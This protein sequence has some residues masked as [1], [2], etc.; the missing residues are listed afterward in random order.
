MHFYVT[1]SSCSVT[2]LTVVSGWAQN[3]GTP[4]E[5]SQEMHSRSCYLEWD[6][7]W[8]SLAGSRL[9]LALVLNFCGLSPAEVED[10][11]SPMSLGFLCFE[12]SQKALNCPKSYV[13]VFPVSHSSL[14]TSTCLGKSFFLQTLRQSQCLDN[15]GRSQ[16]SGW[17]QR[18]GPVE[19]GSGSV[20][21]K[22]FM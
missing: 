1:H 2:S 20:H 19:W 18:M 7:W 5:F 22:H 17:R 11:E 6:P 14:V 8:S 12:L 21:T 16:R 3:L 13:Q 15:F 10:T 9:S 4:A